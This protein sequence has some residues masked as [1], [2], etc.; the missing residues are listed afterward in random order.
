M[1]TLN[2]ILFL[3]SSQERKRAG[4]LLVMIVIMA[5]LEMI[6]VAS[7]L[8]FM[9]VLINPSIIE[10]NFILNSMLRASSIFGVET[11]QQFLFS[12]GII[13]FLL[14]I[15]SISFKAFTSYLQIRFVLMLEHSIGK[16]LVERYLQQTYIW[17]LSRNSADLGKN[18]LS[19]AGSIIVNGM[20][21]LMELISKSVIST[22][23]IT[24]LFI[25]NPKLAFIVGLSLG[26]AYLFIFY[27]VRSYL[28]KSG[29]ERF[30]NNQ[31]RFSIVSEAFGAVKEIKAGGLEKEYVKNFS[32][33]S[34]T[35]A[36]TQT[37]AKLISLLP[38]FI[39]E[40]IAFGGILLII[41]YTVKKGENFNSTIPILSLYVFAGYRLI[42]AL[43]QIYSSFASLTFAGPALNKFY[44]ELKNLKPLNEN[45]DQ[46]ILV[47]H[48]KISLKNIYF[49]YPNKLDSAL[50]NINLDI[51]AKSTV[52][53]IGPT[54]CGKTTLVDIILGLLEA[55][56][57]TLEVDG[58]VITKKNARSWQRSIGYVPQQIYLSDDTVAANIAFGLE[59]G[60]INQDTIEKSAKIAN[61]HNFVVDELP[62]KYQTVI[63]ERGVRLSGGQRQRIGIARA[64]YHNPQLL[65]LDEATNSL[66]NETEQA[67]MDAINNLGKDTTIIMITH[68]LNTLKN[69]DIIF[70]FEKGK[71]VNQGKLKK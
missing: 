49:N 35:F 60:E 71:I 13:V 33:Y 4:L 2:K 62:K 34:K 9:T 32:N 53:L 54:G 58:T 26:L 18:I 46:G 59:P 42:P 57:G 7:I 36:K 47:F 37:L 29:K 23:I 6:G 14:L 17:F 38:R 22:A 20:N 3:L 66:D 48:K 15:I 45:Q 67:V 52:G 30:I 11:Q 25:V 24:L 8:P 64:L 5:S 55:Q 10:T 19:E 65:I 28:H 31:L 16:R 1:Q 51:P 27:F 21:P 41:L 69:C 61:L 68:R 44:D 40:V 63:G 39:L 50:K 56:K 70:K 12:L 43:Q